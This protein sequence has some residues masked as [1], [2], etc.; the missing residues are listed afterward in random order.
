MDAGKDAPVAEFVDSEVAPVVQERGLSNEVLQAIAKAQRRPAAEVA[1]VP[2][3]VV[4]V[5]DRA[6]AARAILE[7]NAAA[8]ANE[9][10]DAAPTIVDAIGAPPPPTI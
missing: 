7:L 8:Q 5:V 9:V 6:V 4:D 1:A 3:Q 10:P 2:A